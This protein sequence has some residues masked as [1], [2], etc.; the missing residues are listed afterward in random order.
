MNINEI[1]ARHVDLAGQLKEHDAK[2]KL[3]VAEMKYIQDLCDHP[4]KDEWTNGHYD[5]STS[6]NIEC[7]DCGYRSST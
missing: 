4:N 6:F 2:R 3:I 5:G 7:P 1:R